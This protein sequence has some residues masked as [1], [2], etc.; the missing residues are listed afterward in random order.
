MM[1]EY[2]FISCNNYTTLLQDVKDGNREWGKWNSVLSAQF[3]CRPNSIQK[4]LLIF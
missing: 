4:N 2:W 3:F 1:Y